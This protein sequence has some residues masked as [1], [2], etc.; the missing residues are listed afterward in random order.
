MQELHGQWV[1]PGDRL[2]QASQFG[3]VGAGCYVRGNH[4]HASVVGMCEITALDAGSAA[5]AADK[6]AAAALPSVSVSAPYAEPPVVPDVGNIVTAKVSA[7]APR[8]TISCSAQSGSL[9]RDVS[10][11]VCQVVSITRQVARVSIVCVGETALK[12][13][14]SGVVRRENIRAEEIDRV[15]V[16]NSMR[17]GDVIV[18][19]VRSWYRG[20]RSSAML[21]NVFSR[22]YRLCHW[23]MHGPTTC[24][25]PKRSLA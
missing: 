6:A 20:L 19:E 1:A 11:C 15:E 13:R 9:T 2:G 25:P 10:P 23:V 17:P 4:V 3:A 21:D 22:A 24:R 14:F 16:Q 12:E 7:V 18:A 5:K 8:P